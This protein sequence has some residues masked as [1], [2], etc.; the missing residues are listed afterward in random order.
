MAE[1]AEDLQAKKKRTSF[2]EKY[3][4]TEKRNYKEYLQQPKVLLLGT[5]DSGKSTVL[6]QFKLLHGGGF[7]A[8]DIQRAKSTIFLNVTRALVLA[9]DLIEDANAEELKEVNLILFRIF[10]N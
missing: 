7:T 2:L 3:L 5:S 1:A 4:K 6:K 10:M 9:L 8:D